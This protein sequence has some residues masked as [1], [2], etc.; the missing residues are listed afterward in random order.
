MFT[1][2]HSN[3]VDVLKSLLV[4]L[5]QQNPP[6]N[7]FQSEQ[8]LVQSPGMSQWLKMEIAQEQGIAANLNFP[9][10]STFIWDMFAQ[11]LPDVPKRSAFNKEAMTWRLMSLLPRF[12][13]Q[14]EFSPLKDYL[15]DDPEQI[16]LYQISSKIADTFD[17]YLVYRPQWID[18]WENSLEVQSLDFKETHKQQAWQPILWKALYQATL[19]AGFSKYHR[20][21]LYQDF[22]QALEAAPMGSIQGLPERLFVFGITALPPRY[23]DALKAMGKHVQVH[24]M[25]SNPCRYYWGDIRDRKYLAKQFAK[26][27]QLLAL[28]VHYLESF[29]LQSENQWRIAQPDE[30]HIDS[31][32]SPLFKKAQQDAFAFVHDESTNQSDVLFSDI[33]PSIH[34]QIGN[35]LL[36]SMGK[37]G[38]ELLYLLSEFEGGE[39]DAFVEVKPTSILKQI[40]SDILSLEEHQD[41]S[42]LL[43]SQHKVEVG[44]DDHSLQVHI[45]HSPMR[46]VEV[47]HDQLLDLFNETPDL[48][49]RDVIVMV[50]DINAYSAAIS[51]VFGNADS[52]KYIPYTLSDRSADQENPILNAFLALLSLP[53]SRMSASQLLAL[54]EIPAIQRKFELSEDEFL[55]AMQWVQAV[56]IRWGIDQTTASQFDLP[57]QAQNTW[58]FGIERMLMGYAMPDSAG[59]FQGD[60]YIASFDEV[61][62]IGAQLA[63]KLAYF[64]RMIRHY[65]HQLSQDYTAMQ[66]QDVLYL[67]LDDFFLANLEDELPLTQI[68]NYLSQLTEQRQAAG[69]DTQLSRAILIKYLDQNLSQ[70]RVSQRFLAGQV[71]FCTLMPMRSI[72]FKVVCLLGMNDGVYPRHVTPDSFDLIQYQHQAGDRSRRDDDRYLFLEALLSAQENLYISY[73]GR[74]I[75]DN[76]PI[77]PS[78][79]VNELLDYCHLNY[80]L[81][82]DQ[83]KEPDDSGDQLIAQLCTE[84][85]RVPY[86][87]A[88]FDGQNKKQQS[89]AKQWLE[90]AKGERVDLP[91]LIQ[92][93]PDYLEHQ[94]L[95]QD[96]MMLEL[97]QLQ[98]FYMLPVRYF[99]NYRL[100]TFFKDANFTQLE[101]DEPFEVKGL[102]RYSI[103]DHLLFEL[104]TARYEQ[105]D[106]LSQSFDFEAT[107]DK[108]L[109]KIQAQGQLPCGEFAQISRQALKDRVWPLFE[110][111]SEKLVDKRKNIEIDL[112][113]DL[114]EQEKKL[115]AQ[116]QQTCHLS[117]WIDSC[118]RDGLIRFRT[119]ALNLGYLLKIWIEHLAMNASGFQLETHIFGLDKNQPQQISWQALS[120]EEAQLHLNDLITQYFQ[121]M[122]SP[123]A[124]F[125]K[126]L[127][128]AFDL[129]FDKQGAWHID[130]ID[131]DKQKNAMQKAFLGDDFYNIGESNDPYIQRV[132]PQ[133][134]LELAQDILS[135]YSAIITPIYQAMINDNHEENA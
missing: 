3:Q 124:L 123:L 6:Q 92:T 65:Q 63:G 128:A 4:A 60:H 54:L 48:T 38:R 133:W 46:E 94:G 26:K 106:A 102:E 80:V 122:N 79:L 100:H 104:L 71:N 14:E 83:E 17:G 39:I 22:I 41:D 45:C 2:Y 33:D 115:T 9:L 18:A 78:V 105:K 118:Y 134:N 95:D 114:L 49:P 85:A 113:F 5:I 40:Q 76:Q 67:L 56:G 20:A 27:R 87:A 81:A 13:D 7:P 37:Q 135:Q 64:V 74:S 120:K 97:A 101:D 16:R 96:V 75:V 82:G 28:N 103:S 43:N 90:I 29:H 62:G 55:K 70:S 112:S 91:T 77:Q 111:I 130:N 116:S 125:P 61:Q 89:Y 99:F 24:F 88:Q 129:G 35:G 73:V 11:V 57:H 34:K 42:C 47:L 127:Q 86:S 8:I 36:A 119:G 58:L 12:L 32:T 21:N 30:E 109:I 10:P 25:L 93:L 44:H 72:P 19:E 51:A 126:T 84:H 23:L 98:R 108:S 66:W 1:L 110:V 50:A 117:G 69:I 31:E 15:N 132:W 68:R 131:R 107:L 53:A 59:L 121:G 52:D